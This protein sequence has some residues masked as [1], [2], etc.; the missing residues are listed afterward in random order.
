[1]GAWASVVAAY[2]LVVVALRLS[3]SLSCGIL[4]PRPEIEPVSLTLADGS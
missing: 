2:W 3:Y 1:M 4:V